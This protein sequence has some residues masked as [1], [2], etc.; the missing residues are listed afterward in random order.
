MIR[1]T[2]LLLGDIA[3]SVGFADQSH[4]TRWFVSIMQETPSRFRHRHR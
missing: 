4:F 2:T 1:D 3:L